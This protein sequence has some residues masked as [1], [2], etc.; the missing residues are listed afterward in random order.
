VTSARM[1]IGG[2]AAVLLMAGC[3]TSTKG[4]GAPGPASTSAAATTADAPATSTASSSSAAATP[5]ASKNVAPVPASPLRTDMI[6]STDGATQYSVKVWVQDDTIDCENHAYGAKVIAYLKANLCR[7]MTRLLAS[8]TVN[9]RPVGIA[10]S[11][12]SFSGGA[13]ADYQAAG[14]FKDL[15]TQNGTGNLNDLLREGKRF[16]NSGTNVGDPDAF[17][18]ESQDAGVGID[19]VWYLDGSTPEND[20]PLLTLAQSLFLQLN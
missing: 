5:S 3:A 1:I 2:I 9:G 19:D 17:S 10:Q 8:T 6:T 15:V 14:N 12:I 11:L 4:S 16:P 20:P 7:G 18:A 13:P